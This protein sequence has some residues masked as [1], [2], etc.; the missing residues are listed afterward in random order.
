MAPVTFTDSRLGPG[1][2]TLGTVDV[3][4]QMTNVKLTPS[5]E[6]IAGTKTLANPKPGSTL[7][8]PEWSLSG[9]SIDDHGNEN[10]FV[11]FC[12]DHHGEEVPFEWVPNSDASLTVTG[13]ALVQAIGWGG[14]IDTQNKTDFEFEAT[15]LDRVYA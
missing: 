5:V 2:L 15:D 4:V 3:A 13:T 9:S 8:A 6:K 12:F 1:T 11:A 14:D 10:G 7:S